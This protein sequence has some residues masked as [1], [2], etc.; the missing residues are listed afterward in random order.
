MP[1][2]EGTTV[3][4]GEGLEAA[5]RNIN[6]WAELIIG[7]LHRLRSNLQ[8]LIDTWNAQASTAY[9][10]RMHEWDVAAVNLFGDE[11]DSGILGT[12]A[13]AMDV[14]YGNY[15]AAEDANL[16]TWRASH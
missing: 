4:V 3:Y 13:T 9:Q 6:G 12:I 2:F 5:G 14:N 7:E 15:V 10:D 16:K 11:A 8:P 1:D